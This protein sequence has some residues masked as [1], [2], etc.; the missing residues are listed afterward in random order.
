MPRR[1][2][3]RRGVTRDLRRSQ[4]IDVAVA[5]N[6]D[7]ISDV[8]PTQL[9][10]VVELV[11]TEA[12]WGVAVVAQDDGLVVKSHAGNGVRPA[13]ARAGRA[14][15]ASRHNITARAALSGTANQWSA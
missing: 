8:D 2:V 13:A 15:Q 7:V 5:V 11:L 6:A 1:V 3:V 9:V 4:F 14:P 12:A 10:L